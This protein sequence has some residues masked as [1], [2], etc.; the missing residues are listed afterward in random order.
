[1]AKALG[2]A[3]DRVLEANTLDLETSREMAVSDTF[4]DWLKLTPQRLDSTVEILDQLADLPDP[5]Q[6][7]MNA[8]YQLNPSQTYCQLMPLGVVALIYEAFPELAAIAAGFC[9]K[10]SGR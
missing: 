3:F 10:R 8:P 1:M 9:I 4:L 7:V 2:N 5:I 6:R